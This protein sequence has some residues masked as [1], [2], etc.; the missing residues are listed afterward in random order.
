MAVIPLKI[1]SGARKA[2]WVLCPIEAAELLISDVPPG[3]PT[4]QAIAKANATV[5]NVRSG[6]KQPPSVSFGDLQPGRMINLGYGAGR[7]RAV[8]PLEPASMRLTATQKRA[9]RESPEAID[10]VRAL[11]D[12][13]SKGL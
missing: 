12:K 6:L 13:L 1:S 4:G 2:F 11:L 10:K 7:P 9:L 5:I 3:V 8:E